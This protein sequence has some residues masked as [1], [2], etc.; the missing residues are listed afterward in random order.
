MKF[1]QD[2]FFKF[3]LVRHPMERLVSCYFDKMVNGTHKSL[4][5]FR[6]F[7]KTRA[8]NIREERRSKG[9][10]ANGVY[11]P[12]PTL[13]DRPLGKKELQS[14]KNVGLVPCKPPILNNLYFINLLT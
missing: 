5:G 6:K 14:L 1:S 9:I 3:M 12:N 7:V 2:H 11:N 13:D 4:K 8:S 10:Y